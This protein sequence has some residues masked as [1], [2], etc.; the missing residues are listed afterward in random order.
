MGAQNSATWKKRLD[1]DQLQTE[2]GKQAPRADE[3]ERIASLYRADEA[4][5]EAGH[6][7]SVRRALA[8][9][10]QTLRHSADAKLKDVYTLN[11]DELA[12][13]L[14]A[15]AT[16]PKSEDLA[17]AA[18]SLNWLERSGRA[19]QIV[20]ATRSRFLRP[21]FFA[22]A[23][24]K[25][26]QAGFT[27]PE[28]QERLNQP[29]GLRDN[30][31]GT[32]M[33][34][35]VY[36]NLQLNVS[37]VPSAENATVNMRLDGAATSQNVGYNGP[38]TIWSS[39]YTQIAATKNIYVDANGIT[40]S[41]TAASC[42]TS[43]T[44]QAIAAKC[45]LI[46]K[47]AWKQAGKKKGQAERIA[48]AH[49][50][51]RIAGQVDA[52]VQNRLAEGNDSTLSKF[53]NRLERRDSF[54]QQLKF[55][56]TDD[57]VNVRMLHAMPNQLATP[58]DP[59]KIGQHDLNV[60]MHESLVT[61]FGESLLSGETLTDERLVEMLT[62]AEAEIPEEIKVTPDKDPWSITFSTVQPVSARFEDNHVRLTIHGRRFTRGE[63][64]VRADIEISAIYR[65]ERS[66]GGSKLT[67][68]GEVSVEY[69]SRQRL[70]VGQV[71]MKTFLRKKFDA[72][73]KEEFKSEGPKLPERLKGLGKL[74]LQELSADKGWLALAWSQASE[75]PKTAMLMLPVTPR[76]IIQEEQEEK[77]GID[78]TP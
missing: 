40:T 30:I 21:N 58:S 41:G 43:S 71:A 64:V 65:L 14:E 74:Q 46:E 27:D 56:S 35:T 57:V 34:G 69:V 39:G 55:S 16:S 33:Q 54:P 47:M 72:L 25:L 68:E 45:G 38:V 42:W 75:A 19:P 31:L 6:F 70:S 7:A 66:G 59:P 13:R 8:D 63:Q 78:L 52:Q 49:A 53:R 29:Q 5:L 28:T 22:T 4:G 18:R 62:E 76:V 15:M 1:W 17:A 32:S 26:V 12:K 3:L 36:P 67:R 9:H 44:I 2:L 11:L 23:S 50:Q 77:L 60:R 48:S 37:L 20:A 24:E 61:N 10:A 51:A 73:F